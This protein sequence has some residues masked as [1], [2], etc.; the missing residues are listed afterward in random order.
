MASSCWGV[1]N[2]AVALGLNGAVGLITPGA[3]QFYTPEGKRY[4]SLKVKILTKT[5]KFKLFYS[6]SFH[7]NGP[8]KNTLGDR[9]GCRFVH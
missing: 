8:Y 4:K 5:L 6:N 2:S 1:P 9:P 7:E 3:I